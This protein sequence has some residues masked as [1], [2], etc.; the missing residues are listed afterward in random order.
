MRIPVVPPVAA[1][2]EIRRRVVQAQP[3][4]H[5]VDGEVVHGVLDGPAHG[6]PE[7]RRDVAVREPVGQGAAALGRGARGVARVVVVGRHD[8]GVGE[9][10][11]EAVGPVDGAADALDVGVGEDVVGVGAA[12]RRAVPEGGPRV[13]QEA[14]V[15]PDVDKRADVLLVCVGLEDV[16]EGGAATEL[17]LV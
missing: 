2:A 9:H 15:P 4:R 17:L 6:A 16:E 10:G 11:G 5:G 3:A 7:R 12:L 8:L 14:D 1:A 13:G